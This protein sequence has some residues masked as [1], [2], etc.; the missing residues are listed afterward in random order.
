[1][2]CEVRRKSKEARSKGAA[3][4]KLASVPSDSIAWSPLEQESFPKTMPSHL[5]QDAPGIFSFIR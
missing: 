5:F 2:E 3:S 4:S 1:M